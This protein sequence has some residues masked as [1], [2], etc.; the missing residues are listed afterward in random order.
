MGT[1]VRKEGKRGGVVV[2]YG[3]RAKAV[4]YS[5]EAR[6]PRFRTVVSAKLALVGV[7]YDHWG[8]VMRRI[9]HA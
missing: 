7:F 8:T 2:K 1:E 9:R 3:Q 6:A 4:L 5:G